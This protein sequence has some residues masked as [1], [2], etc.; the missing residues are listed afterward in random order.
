MKTEILRFFEEPGLD[1]QMERPGDNKKTTWHF[2]NM[3]RR[4]MCWM[5]MDLQIIILTIH[6][7]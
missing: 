6:P 7:A 2:D 4:Q 1:G 3:G 5:Q